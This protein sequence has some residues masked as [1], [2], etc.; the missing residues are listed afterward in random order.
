MDIELYLTMFRV[1]PATPFGAPP[2]YI[3]IIV[4][5]PHS[6]AFFSLLLT[7]LPIPTELLQL[8]PLPKTS[9]RGLQLGQRMHAKCFF[10]CCPGLT[11]TA[12]CSDIDD[13]LETLDFMSRGING[14][15]HTILGNS[16]ATPPLSGPF[17][18]IQ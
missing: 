10:S 3:T 1:S 11:A 4:L 15:T 2:L 14:H 12:T 7:S 9:A 5:H 16:S 18:T 6:P 17:P 8:P 13:D